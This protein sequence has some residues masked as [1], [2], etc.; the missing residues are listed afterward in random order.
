MKNRMAY[1]AQDLW[2]GVLADDKT[3][4]LKRTASCGWPATCWAWQTAI[5]RRA[6]QAVQGR[7]AGIAYQVGQ[8]RA[9]WRR[10]SARHGFQPDETARAGAVGHG[11]RQFP[12]SHAAGVLHAF[13]AASPCKRIFAT[14]LVAA[15][16]TVM[17]GFLA[18]GI[19]AA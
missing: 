7:K 5:R 4:T 14:V 15:V 12:P 9:Q 11:S 18:A 13:T 8:R 10:R 1:V 3:A 19:N 2:R 16:S 17:T 6:R